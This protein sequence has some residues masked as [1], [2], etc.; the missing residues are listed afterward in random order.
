M[1]L[2]YFVSYRRNSQVTIRETDA[3]LLKETTMAIGD[4]IR[5]NIASIAPT[6]RALLRDALI[7]LNHR[8]FP[9]SRTD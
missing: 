9:G 7:A 3:K 4:G 2:G 8:F 5:R 1:Y 6:K